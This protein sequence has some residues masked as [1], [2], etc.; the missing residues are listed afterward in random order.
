MRDQAQERE[1][2]PES[3]FL[4]TENPLSLRKMEKCEQRE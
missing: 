1:D 2:T 4:D 3:G